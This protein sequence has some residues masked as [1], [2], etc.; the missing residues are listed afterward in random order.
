MVRFGVPGQNVNSLAYADERLSVVP[1]VHAPREPTTS[2]KKFPMWCEWRISKSPSSGTEGDFWKL[3]KF[4]S[5]GNATW[6]KFSPSSGTSFTGLRD[7]VNANVD[8]NGSTNRIDIDGLV[9]AN[10]ANPSSIPL[11]SVAG[12]NVLTMQIQVGKAR[13]G[14][15][16]NKNDA[17]LLSANDTQ[18]SVDAN[19][20][21]SLA[22]SGGG[23]PILKL[24][25]DDSNTATPT[26]V[27][28]ITIAGGPGITTTAT[29]NTLTV[30]SVVYSNQTATTLTADSGTWATAAGAYT[31]PA[32]PANGEIVEIVCITTGIVVTANT[33][34]EIQIG[35]D[36][37]STAGTATNSAKGDALV[38]RYRNTD[39]AWYAISAVGVWTLA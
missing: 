36:V 7:Q 32:A 13:T 12:T 31:L 3:V 16:A 34:Q 10:A 26:A 21:L 39:T 24:Q 35:G 15:P 19:G 14:A 33:G 29:G 38:L 5:N 27:G 2:D 17:G 9:V 18:F 37:T 30:N 28:I 20:Y 25:A 6:V 8:P 4:E 11:E 23:A 1:V 22:G